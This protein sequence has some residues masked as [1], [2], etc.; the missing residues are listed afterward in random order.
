M[1]PFPS[2]PS[3]PWSQALNV[4][5][6]I[7][8]KEE[9]IKDINFNYCLIYVILIYKAAYINIDHYMEAGNSAVPQGG[10]GAAGR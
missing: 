6:K 5:L 2:I 7:I 1:P 8:T 4:R 9:Y 10:P 3:L